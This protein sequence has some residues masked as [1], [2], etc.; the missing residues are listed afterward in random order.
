MLRYVSTGL[1]VAGAQEGSGDCLVGGAT[2]SKANTAI[3]LSS[4]SSTKPWQPSTKPS[5]PPYKTTAQQVS[6]GVPDMA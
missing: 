2:Y 3:R 1:H 4:L 6:T 5:V